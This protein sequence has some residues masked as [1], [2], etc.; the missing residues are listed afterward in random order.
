MTHEELKKLPQWLYRDRGK[1]NGNYY[2]VYWGLDRDNGQENGK[3]C[4]VY[5]ALYRDNGKEHENY[6]RVE[7]LGYP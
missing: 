4:L 6:Y 2:V 7:G 1:E 3:Y 5:W